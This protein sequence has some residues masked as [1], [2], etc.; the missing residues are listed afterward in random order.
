M[1][2]SEYM[3]QVAADTGTDLDNLE[4]NVKDIDDESKALKDIL[5]GE[6]GK[7]GVVGA[8]ETEIEAV[9]DITEMYATLRSELDKVKSAYE[10]VTAAI[11]ATIRAQ[12]QI[13][14]NPGTSTT[15][16]N[17]SSGGK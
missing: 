12:S 3:D 10:E 9:K 16:Y 4:K 2:W 7:G 15:K 11:N 13:S 17:S 5:I 8:I 14:S 6:D 1:E